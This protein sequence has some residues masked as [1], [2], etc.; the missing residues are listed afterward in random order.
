M[1]KP[2]SFTQIDNLNN[3]RNHQ[4]ENNGDSSQRNL[5]IDSDSNSNKST[6]LAPKLSKSDAA[7][8]KHDGNDISVIEEDYFSERTE[9]NE[10]VNSQIES[11]AQALK[12]KL[13]KINNNQL[14]KQRNAR[15]PS[16][17]SPNYQSAIFERK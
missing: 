4:V 15:R 5:S 13:K 14:D 12:D 7:S 6:V 17:L 10:D 1:R 2:N 11:Q 9:V 3:S 8:F 16:N